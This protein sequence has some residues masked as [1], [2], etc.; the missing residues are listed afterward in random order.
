MAKTSKA[1]VKDSAGGAYKCLTKVRLNGTVYEIG[2]DIAL[3][4]EEAQQL[5]LAEA[6]EPKAKKT[7]PAG[8]SE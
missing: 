7:S 2:G 5:L 1:P 8:D 6:V 3:T 4:G